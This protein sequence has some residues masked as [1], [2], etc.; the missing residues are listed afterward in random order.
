MYENGILN[1][2][3]G[4]SITRQL[5]QANVLLRPA[6]YRVIRNAYGEIVLRGNGCEY[7]TDNVFDAVGTAQ[8]EARAYAEMLVSCHA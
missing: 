7:F 1:R 3:E 6:G 8:A 2:F 4:K 5:K